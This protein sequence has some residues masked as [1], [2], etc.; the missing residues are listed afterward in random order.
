[1]KLDL[2]DYKI[3]LKFLGRELEGKRAKH[4]IYDRESV[5]ILADYVTL[6][7]GTGCV[8]TAPGHGQEDYESGLKYNIDIYAPVD[9]YGKFTDEVEY[10]AGKFVFDANEDVNKK[11][12]EVGALLKVEDYEHQYPHCWRCKNPIVF[13]S[14]PQWFISMDKN[15]L[16]KTAL[17]E[18]DRVKW[19]PKWGRDRIYGMIENRPDWC[20]SRQRSWGVPITV[21]YCN[22]CGAEIMD[23][24]IFGRVSDMFDEG[25]ADVWFEKEIEE[26]TGPGYKC[27]KCGGTEFT[28]E[29]DILDVWFDSG[30]SYA[31]VCEK[32]KD[33]KPIPDMYLEGSDQHRG[34]F[35]SSLLAS[36]GTR[37]HA[38]YREVLTH[39]FLVDG[40][41]RKMSKSLGNFIAVEDVIEQ[42]GAEII[43]LWVSAE[44]YREDI[45]ISQEI[46]KRMSE[47]YRRIRNTSRFI[48]GNLY[49]FDPKKNSVKREDLS[50]L[51]R[52]ILIKFTRLIKRVLSAFEDFDF[53][54][55]YH[56]IHNFCAVNLSAF[57][58]DVLKD[59]L[60]IN[61]PSSKPRRAAQSTMY[62]ILHD[63]VRLMAPILVFTADEIWENLPDAEKENSVHLT[64]FPEPDDSYLDDKLEKD[65]DD[66]LE[67]RGEVTK[68]LEEARRE[69]VIGH[70]LDAMVTLS[71]TG[72]RQELLKRYE[73]ELSNI[74]IVSKVSVTDNP[75]KG[76]FQSEEVKGLAISVARASGEKCPRCWHYSE[77]IGSEK[78]Y[79]ETCGRCA[80]SLEEGKAS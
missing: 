14:T 60:Y 47:A 63:I 40:E 8:H 18:I 28:K 75:P 17:S 19:I 33:L 25:G 9:D 1:M 61:A 62:I 57:Y 45:R 23:E 21:L 31:A 27:K 52:Y 36:V 35:H 15:D 64:S 38:P 78:N 56:S 32:R 55:I 42:Y 48:L 39:G 58:L 12:A 50:E 24:K 80:K 51:D 5:I 53:H 16:R 74:F 69:K 41:G 3:L 10:F 79:P 70:S 13:R 71:A 20:I 11:L 46:L 72:K 4:P 22:S 26:I 73:G 77:E 65:W 7:A 76:A 6:D 43:R 44:D 54:V 2:K 68:A 67:A 66:I 34:W 37:K 29:D 59:R 49:D 30:V